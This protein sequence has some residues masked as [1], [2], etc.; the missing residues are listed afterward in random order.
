MVADCIDPTSIDSE[1]IHKLSTSSSIKS[2][3]YHVAVILIEFSYFF[4]MYIA[5][6]NLIKP[7]KSSLTRCAPRLMYG[8][9]MMVTLRGVKKVYDVY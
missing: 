1:K 5:I 6:F 7:F 2:H 3:N 8:V 9:L 4:L